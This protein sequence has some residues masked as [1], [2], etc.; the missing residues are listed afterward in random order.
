MNIVA[1]QWGCPAI[2]YGP[3]DS[4]LDHTPD[5]HLELAEYARAVE[6]LAAALEKLAKDRLRESIFSAG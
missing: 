3:G 6:V 1:P 2:V 4:S 5:E